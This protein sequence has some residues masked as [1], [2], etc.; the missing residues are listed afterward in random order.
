MPNHHFPFGVAA[1]VEKY[2]PV[3]LNAAFDGAKKVYDH[4]VAVSN[5]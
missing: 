1:Y 2:A 3:L 4:V 5:A